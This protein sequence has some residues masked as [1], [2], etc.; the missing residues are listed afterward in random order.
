[1][2]VDLQ[3]LLN[4]A[5]GGEPATEPTTPT[6]PNPTDPNPADPNP[7]DPNPTDPNPTDPATPPT[8]PNPA[9]PNKPAEPEKKTN[10]M[11]EV[12]DKLN[13][14]QKIREKISNAIQRFSDGNYT[15]AIKDFKDDKGKVD[16]DALIAAM[17][18][19]DN[20]VKAEAK[21]ITPEVQA[22]IDRIEKEKIEIQKAKLQ[23][24][25]DRAI[26]DLQIE[27]GL[28]RVAVN[29][30]FKDSLEQNKNPYQWL[31]QG[32]TLK[33]LYYLIYRESIT[34]KAVD[35]AVAA[36]KAEWESKNSKVPPT[37][38]PATPSTSNNP[39]GLSIDDLKGLA[40]NKK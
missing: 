15:F 4:E 11:K 5:A 34:K 32:G 6:E 40:S 3:S 17:D 36:A 33:D 35:D 28:D 7:T 27:Q 30:F 20:K 8:E 12:R 16:Y 38:N 31:N 22:E 18:E 9:E 19:A 29:N 26:S 1:M 39:D 21:V 23:V 10:P 2:Q 24:A 13:S 37:P 25:M 14:E